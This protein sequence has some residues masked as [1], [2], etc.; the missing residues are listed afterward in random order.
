M[1]RL[2]SSSLV[3]LTMT[4]SRPRLV[5]TSPPLTS[6]LLVRCNECDLAERPLENRVLRDLLAGCVLLCS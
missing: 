2:R 1:L 4:P 3:R 5:V 6:L